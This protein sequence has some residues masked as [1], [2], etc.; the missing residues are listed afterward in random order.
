MSLITLD[1]FQVL[2]HQLP[3]TLQQCVRIFLSLSFVADIPLWK[4]FLLTFMSLDRLHFRWTLAFLA[5]SLHANTVC[6]YFCVTW[7]QFHF[8]YASFFFFCIKFCQE[9]CF[10]LQASSPLCLSSCTWGW[11]ILEIGV[12]GFGK[13]TSSPTPLYFFPGLYP[14]VH[15]EQAHPEQAQVCS[16]EG[17]GCDPAFCFVLSLQDLE[18]YHFT[19]NA[20]KAPAPTHHIPKQFFLVCKKHVQQSISLSLTPWSLLLGNCHPCT[21]K[22]PRLFL[23]SYIVLPAD[24]QVV[25]VPHWNL[26]YHTNHLILNLQTVV[27]W[28]GSSTLLHETSLLARPDFLTKHIAQNFLLLCSEAK[29]HLSLGI[30]LMQWNIIMWFRYFIS[31]WFY[32]HLCV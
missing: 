10:S 5:L 2:C 7:H 26:G 20:A 8:L 17:Q 28:R 30:S 25:E 9:L 21:Q 27:Q 31:Q 3:Y 4:P 12:C 15:P 6:L 32:P 13:S 29:I 23:P 16:L 1:F 19:F 22:P 18:H 14:T 24:K 11:T